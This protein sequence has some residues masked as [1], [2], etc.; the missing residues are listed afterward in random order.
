MEGTIGR[1]V[2]LDPARELGIGRVHD[3]HAGHPD[4]VGQHRAE[5]E[6][7]LV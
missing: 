5:H 4:Q 1:V 7:R 6:A 2:Q 3:T